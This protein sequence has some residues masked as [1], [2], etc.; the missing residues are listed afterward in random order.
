MV[1]NYLV[2]KRITNVKELQEDDKLIETNIDN[3]LGNKEAQEKT[4][5]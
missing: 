1:H 3:I 4:P 2:L 5:S